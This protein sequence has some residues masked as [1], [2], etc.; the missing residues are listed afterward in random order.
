MRDEAIT[1]RFMLLKLNEVQKRADV[2]FQKMRRMEE[3][4]DAG[5]VRCVSCGRFHHFSQVDSGHFIPRAHKGTR[6]ERFNVWPQCK[7]CNYHLHGNTS[8]FRERLVELMS[9]E[10]VENMEA[11]KDKET[12][13]P[14]SWREHCIDIYLSSKKRIKELSNHL[15]A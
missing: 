13:H 2:V 3:A 12:W 8:K 4:N 14:K 7:H 9:K 1:Q 5:V 15:V 11:D 10:G 6:Y